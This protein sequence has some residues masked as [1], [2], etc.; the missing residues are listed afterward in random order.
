MLLWKEVESGYNKKLSLANLEFSEGE[1]IVGRFSGG[2]SGQSQGINKKYIIEKTRF[3]W[4]I[5][6][7]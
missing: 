3:L 1:I 7:E 4:C 6:R 5:A 2:C